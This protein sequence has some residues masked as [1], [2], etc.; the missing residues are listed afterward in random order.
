MYCIGK[1]FILLVSG[2]LSDPFLLGHVALHAKSSYFYS[3]LTWLFTIE[4]QDGW[5]TYCKFRAL[6]SI[7]IVPAL[8]FPFALKLILLSNIQKSLSWKQEMHTNPYGEDI[9]RLPLIM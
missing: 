9:F 2:R 5:Q 3:P 4:L 7:G 1:S 6:G 8:F